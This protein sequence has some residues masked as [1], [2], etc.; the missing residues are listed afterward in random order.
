MSTAESRNELPASIGI[1]L[2]TVFVLGLIYGFLTGNVFLFAL[3]V[4]SLGVTIYA[5]FLFYRLV[6]A[7]EEIAATM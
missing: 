7:V 4:P 2:A 6:V 5:L 1:V 3:I